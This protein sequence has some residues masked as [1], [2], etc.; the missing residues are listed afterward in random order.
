[1]DTLTDSESG[2]TK[3]EYSHRF[4]KN[5]GA[6]KSSDGPDLYPEP[7]SVHVLPQMESKDK[8]AD[9]ISNHLTDGDELE[10]SKINLAEEDSLAAGLVEPRDPTLAQCLAENNLAYVS[11][12]DWSGR[13]EE[14]AAEKENRKEDTV[15]KLLPSHNKGRQR[16]GVI[17]L[18]RGNS[19][20][21]GRSEVI[22][23]HNTK[24]RWHKKSDTSL[25]EEGILTNG[26]LDANDS[27][28][29]NSTSKA[30]CAAT[31][32][33]ADGSS[34]FDSP[35]S[36]TASTHDT[37]PNKLSPP[38]LSNQGRPQSGGFCTDNYASRP[39]AFTSGR[40]TGRDERSSTL[41][42]SKTSSDKDGT[43][44]ELSALWAQAEDIMAGK[45][46]KVLDVLAQFG[47]G[48]GGKD[49]TDEQEEEEEAVWHVV[50]SKVI[51]VDR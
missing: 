18:G 40:S 31:S 9:R 51:A 1:M 36:F 16:P 2:V 42:S 47:V 41:S 30:F 46:R 24:H 22:F 11:N 35:A 3:M 10:T 17:L 4:R 21:L 28:P 12:T 8:H 7:D 15:G 5:S 20:S 37:E 19:F 49:T 39:I 34:N 26:G 29:T 23:L 45:Q 6:R 48:D 32:S 38:Q 50:E 14:G 43:T 27:S 25:Q 13:D 44:D 33:G